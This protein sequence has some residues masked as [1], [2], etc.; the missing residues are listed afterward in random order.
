MNVNKASLPSTGP[1]H[2]WTTSRLRRF[3][4]FFLLM[5]CLPAL[6]CGFLPFA[7]A[8]A[9]P[10]P[11][12][13]NTPPPT[14]AAT[15]ALTF[16]DHEVDGL[17]LSL[18]YPQSWELTED[19]NT[20]V[21]A[22]DAELLTAQQ[23]DH[24][25][26]G[27]MIVVDPAASVTG[28]TLEATLENAMRQFSFTDNDQIV[29]GPRQL[30]INGQEAV[31]ATIEGSDLD[32]EQALVVYV[33]LLRR[34]DR[35]AFVAAVTLQ[36]TLEQYRETL[37]V[38]SNSIVLDEVEERD[39]G[40]VQGE[41]QYG[42]TVNGEVVSGRPSN[43]TFI[44]VEGESVDIAARPLADDLDLT[45]DVRNTDGESI[46]D[47]GPVDDSFGVETIRGLTL[48]ASA[49]FTIVVSGFEQASG[50]FELA[51]GES[52][53]LSSAQAI[54]T[55]DTLNGVL[56]I[57]GQDDY[58]FTSDNRDAVTIVVNPVGDLD[59]VVE[60][61]TV[62]GEVVFQQDSSYGQEQL[63]FTPET[64]TD[65]ILRVR[66]Y[67]GASGDYAITLQA[68]GVGSTG[69]T[70]VTS[71]T[72]E[73]DD[74]EGHNFPFTVDQGEIVQAIVTPE[75]EFDVVVE[76]WNVDT[77]AMEESVDA[78][79]GREQVTFTAAQTGNY[80]F[81]VLGFEGQGGS[82][83]V[84]LSGS[85][86]VIFE[87]VTGDQVS[88]DMGQSTSIDYHVRLAPG[89]TLQLDASPDSD[90]DIVLEVLDLS[91][92]LLASADEGFE[93][94]SEQLSYVAPSDAAEDA[95]YILRVRDFSGEPG[96]TFSLNVE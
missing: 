44:G 69:T 71:A 83:S 20:V 95:V 54:S 94:E 7:S 75:G 90:T 64:E 31:T 5:M 53:A 45:V 33:T 50:P 30:I 92:N 14:V 57:D 27:V 52:G 40:E 51:V 24:E 58:L 16:V 91:E 73:P 80:Y 41:L 12:S 6:A 37:Q 36:N 13:T 87:L 72:L 74:S 23:F 21:V 86:G 82:Y 18:R 19:E 35:A 78:S 25:G 65:Y 43:W 84:T 39:I 9:T 48:P 4:L 49:Q 59:V 10:E 88:A 89:A 77:G 32:G 79:F 42:E 38:V 62:D 81:K 63:S 61:L 34:G 22:S 2:L 67:A 17:G 8:T 68:G 15:P 93:G 60:V 85:P 76:V 47:S 28:D 55:G 96:G 46:L 1:E 66:G 56:E 26:A 29:E 3:G 11:A 70:L